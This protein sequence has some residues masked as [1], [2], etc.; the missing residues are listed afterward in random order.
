MKNEKNLCPSLMA[1]HSSKMPYNLNLYSLQN[2]L[3]MDN[4]K[5]NQKEHDL[6]KNI[7][8]GD[9][10]FLSSQTIYNVM[11]EANGLNMRWYATV[12]KHQS[13]KFVC[14]IFC[15]DGYKDEYLKL[16]SSEKKKIH[17]KIEE[18]VINIS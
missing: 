10:S 7:V 9:V 1:R 4:P 8:I 15:A 11:I 16:K 3:L 18:I 12:I 5:V 14:S 2:N 13:E 17:K 6:P